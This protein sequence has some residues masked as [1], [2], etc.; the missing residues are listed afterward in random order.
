MARDNVPFRKMRHEVGIR[1]FRPRTL[2][3]SAL[4]GLGLDAGAH[5]L[6]ARP[7]AGPG[8]RAGGRYPPGAATDFPGISVASRTHRRGRLRV[9]PMRSISMRAASKPSR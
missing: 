8:S 1:A 6:P 9:P 5:R 3:D 2:V 7:L 4:P